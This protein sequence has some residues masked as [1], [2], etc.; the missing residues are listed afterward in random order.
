[1]G[2]EDYGKQ[3]KRLESRPVDVVVATPGRLVKHLQAGNV[4]LGSVRH[5]VIDE[6][7]TMLEQGFQSDLGT[8]LHPLLYQKKVIY[9]SEVDRLRLVEG[10]LKLC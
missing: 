8:I 1:M 6:F 10:H 2:G 7:D 5:V 9:P 3:R 4:F